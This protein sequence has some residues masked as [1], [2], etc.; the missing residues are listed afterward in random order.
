MNARELHTQSFRAY[1]SLELYTYAC[2]HNC[3]QYLTAY[4]FRAVSK[5]AL[6]SSLKIDVELS[7]LQ[8]VVAQGQNVPEN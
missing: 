2:I 6:A 3:T 1:L 8:P 4:I 7:A 5:S